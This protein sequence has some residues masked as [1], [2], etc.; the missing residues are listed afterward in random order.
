M[1]LKLQQEQ[2]SASILTS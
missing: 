1:S 2:S